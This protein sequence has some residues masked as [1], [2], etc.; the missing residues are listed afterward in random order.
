MYKENSR[1]KKEKE[2]KKERVGQ[3]LPHVGAESTDTI[4]LMFLRGK[5]RGDGYY[6]EPFPSVSSRIPNI[7]TNAARR[8]AVQKLKVD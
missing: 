3:K 1:Q 4:C 8:R 2:R 7:L 6:T 5:Q